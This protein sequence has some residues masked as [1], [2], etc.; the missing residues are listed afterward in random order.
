MELS[1]QLSRDK[2]VQL[3]SLSPPFLS[4]DD[5]ARFA[6]QLIGDHRDVQY[7]GAILK[8][9]LGQYFATRPVKAHGV[10]FKP[11]RV[12]STD[13]SGKFKHPP[14]YTCIAFYHSHADTYEQLQVLYEGWPIEDLFTRASFFSP[15]DVQAML[16]TAS[17][18][19]A[20]Y[21]SGLNGSLIKYQSSGSAEEKDF[22]GLI[23]EAKK[24]A[25]APFDKLVEVVRK[26][27]DIGTVSVIQSTEIWGQRT[28]PLDISFNVYSP[29]DTLDIA[30]VIVQRPAF[31]PLVFSEPQALD[32]LRSRV[33]QTPE[34][35]YGVILKH[36]QRDEFV[37][38]EP[39]TGTKDFSLNRVFGKSREGVPV[40][41]EGYAVFALYGCDGEH[42]DPTLIP[43]EQASL[44]KNLMH[45]QALEQGILLARLMGKPAEQ[46][47]LPL[48]IAA[49]DGAML[50]YVSRYSSDEKTLFGKLSE[51]EGGGME[52]IRNLLA[53]VENSLNYIHLLAHA[54]E[55][56]VVHTSDLWSRAGRV[57][58]TW[59]PFDG[60]MRRNLGPSFISADDAARYAHEQI[61]GRVD[62]V[63]GGLIFQR[64]ERFFASEPM[65][66]HTETFDPQRVIPP[67][68]ASYTPFSAT[69]V[70]VYQ[71]HRIHPLHLWRSPV[72]E[73][74]RRNMFDPH[75]LCTAIKE[76]TWAKV[77]YLSTQEGALL[78]Y[79]P[80]GS[81]LELQFLPR[82]APPAEHP[83]Q[84][85]NNPT[86]IRLRANSLKPSEYVVQITRVGDLQVVVGSALWGSRGPV[87]PAW[88]PAQ[89]RSDTGDAKVLPAFGP[90]FT[91]A[92]D[93]M[94]YV[95]ERMGT[96]RQRQFGIILKDA[97]EDE[98]IVTEPLYAPTNAM[99]LS[100]VLPRP[101]GAPQ[102]FLPDGFGYHSVYVAAPEQP[103]EPV[104]G[105]V[106]A[107]FVAPQVLSDVAVLMSTV[108]DQLPAGAACPPLFISTRDGA[109]LSYRTHSLNPLLSLD[110]PFSFQSSM[111]VGLISGKV[112]PT[113][114][115]RHVAGSGQLDVHLTSS[116]WATEGR[117]T[118][119]WRPSA[120]DIPLSNGSKP[121][122]VALGPHFV[123]IDDAALYCHRRLAHPHA[124]NVVGA[125]FR[126]VFEGKYVPLEPE[127]NGSAA[128]APEHVFINSLQEQSSA[129]PRSQPIAPYGLEP[130][131][132]YYAHQ[133]V[134]PIFARAH[135]REWIDN[136]FR[137]LDICYLTKSL[138]RLEFSLD[139]AFLS[140]NDGALLKYV[141]RRTQ[142]ENALCERVAGSDYWENRYLDQ[143]WIDQGQQT[144]SQ[145]I[146]KLLE[147]GELVVVKASKNW[148]RVGWVTSNWR[149]D[150][151]AK[152]PALQPWA[153]SA[154]MQD[155]DEL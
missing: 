123:H 96:R 2:T 69:A 6:H 153:R 103:L 31:G 5:A 120:F 10:L 124:K 150:Q 110:G 78:K 76:R 26:L 144:E 149:S 129:T 13:S 8:N 91:Q 93:A 59:Q 43:A 48:F 106:Y 24:H 40:L 54:G 46:R 105:D 117:V 141:R 121:H 104:A 151:P 138:P 85:R 3:P 38:S 73:Q 131:A 116:L 108:R 155:K 22:A 79:T 45:P 67:E 111:L 17:F 77:R 14:G 75:E 130:W 119:A 29:E 80:S 62:A 34:S 64:G 135:P 113:E 134:T 65:A 9:S 98:F 42:R 71:S 36:A 82:I 18:A 53:D 89:P 83:E 81:E 7:G 145:Y 1:D 68:R 112:R 61:G 32:Y 30:P 52:L 70:A 97:Y 51:A 35:H 137:P 15:T 25:L 87:T 47:A 95:H 86:E 33:D 101:F 152:A 39:V 92:L 23:T 128:N 125:I 118:M 37:V 41:Y 28:G 90:I 147:A 100:R 132:V 122:G 58:T 63:Y 72:E 57:Q 55:L 21:L 20:S 12:M 127:H 115:V 44:F 19:P 114:Y 4:A 50:K 66:V 49:R 146:N 143:E 102:Y 136:A 84:V 16:S 139:I 11:E 142:A 109:L 140:G 99:G 154:P 60:F 27:V 148:S 133:P 88:K 56:S 74:V 94:R 126:T 107:N